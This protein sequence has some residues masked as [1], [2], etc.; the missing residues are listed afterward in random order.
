MNW[1]TIGMIII[2]VLILC[3]I[4]L[5]V[6]VKEGFDEDEQLYLEAKR[7]L[8][9]EYQRSLRLNTKLKDL[10]DNMNWNSN[11]N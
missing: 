3:I 10:R 6:R 7:K 11:N 5:S 2:G 4:M 9:S 8:K 1:F